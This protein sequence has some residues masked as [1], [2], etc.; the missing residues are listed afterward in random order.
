M[1]YREYLNKLDTICVMNVYSQDSVGQLN[2]KTLIAKADGEI[3]DKEAKELYELIEE[4][5]KAY[6]KLGNKTFELIKKYREGGK[7]ETTE[8]EDDEYI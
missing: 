7:E 8:T 5:R 3:T 6:C 1:K 4:V 2:L